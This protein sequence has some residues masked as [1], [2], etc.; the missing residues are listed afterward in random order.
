MTVS[1]EAAEQAMHWQLELQAPDVSE[2][3]R[4]DWRRWREEDPAHERA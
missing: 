3:T 1:L 2:Q 4:A